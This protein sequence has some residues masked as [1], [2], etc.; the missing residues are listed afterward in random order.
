MPGHRM[1]LRAATGL[2][3]GLAVAIALALATSGCGSTSA[4]LDPVAQAAEV[5]SQ[6]GGAHIALTAQV[7]VAAL[8]APLTINGQGFF[9]YKTQEGTIGLDMSGL[10]TAAAAGLA[11][12]SL[13]MEEIFKS[14]ALYIGSPL[15]A[16]KLPGG[17]HWMKLDIARFGQA[18]GIDLQSLTG[19]QSNPAQFL[20]Y[21]KASGGSVTA[22][23]HELVRGVPT[24]HYRGAIDLRKV[25][26]VLP[27]GNRAQLHAAL[28]K[29]IAQIG[30]SSLPVEVWVD[31]GRLVRRIAI[32]L[33]APA[34]GQSL[35]MQMTVELFGFGP[36]PAV[37][38]PAQ[39][40]V[41]DAT[42]AALA[43]LSASGG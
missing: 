36:T 25:A 19:G 32:V 31:S 13:H 8:S 43:G 40:D 12:G 26:D 42:Q 11:G 7:S 21:L 2:V 35:R 14:A 18:L 20:E 24:T 37:T 34:G 4:T 6:A 22:V 41:Y 29:V 28:A 27:G 38:A 5:T 15:F 1:R 10:P 17:A 30:A 16:G 39:G 9:N 3:P 33:S 23:G